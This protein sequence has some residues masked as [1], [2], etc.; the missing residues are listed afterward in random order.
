MTRSWFLA[1]AVALLA[2]VAVAQSP[3]RVEVF[4]GF[5][6]VTNDFSL[7]SGNGLKGWDASAN[8]RIAPYVGFAADFSGYYPSGCC[9]RNKVHTFLFG[10]QVSFRLN[11]VTPFAHFLM[12]SAN[13]SMA[14]PG[15]FALASYRAFTYAAGGGVDF[16]LTRRLALRGQGDWLHTGFQTWDS[17][18]SDPPNGARILTG[19]VIRF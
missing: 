17:Q 4:G 14:A 15:A 18:G 1:L 6:Y 5:S 7:T 16:S 8:F 9:G 2:R 11:R 12:G 3:D 13:L 19:I 10:P